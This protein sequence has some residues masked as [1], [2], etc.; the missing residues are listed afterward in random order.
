[1]PPARAGLL[2]LTVMSPT[3][4][5][6]AFGQLSGPPTIDSAEEDLYSV[7]RA[8]AD[9]MSW[10]ATSSPRH[11]LLWEMN[12]AELTAGIDA[13]RI[14]WLQVGLGVG[15]FEP[16]S[17][18]SVPVLGFRY[19]QL[20]ARRRAI[21]PVMAL[22]ALVEC[23]NDSLS[24]FGVVELSSLQVMANGLETNREDQLGYLVSVLNWFNVNL[25]AKTDGIVAFD[26]DLL[27]D[28]DV[29]ELVASL[30][31]RNTGSFEFGPVV[32]VPEQHSTKAGVEPPTSSISA[33]R[34][35]LGVSVALP[36]WTA[37]AVGWVLAMVIDTARTRRPDV[38]DFTVRVTRM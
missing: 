14:G 29:S 34:S 27:G 1:M 5:L 32:A 13:S 12:D 3:L 2:V 19:A 18:P 30:Q 24:R 10:A 20:G 37:S 28:H 22:P 21:D 6:E 26:Q 9:F 15:N 17:V 33:A 36:E 8:R 4:F 23:F 25:K 38:S 35:G 16:T 7:F 31:W 11:P